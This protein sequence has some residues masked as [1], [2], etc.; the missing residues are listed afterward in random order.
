MRQNSPRATEVAG[1]WRKMHSQVAMFPCE[2]AAT[3]PGW[4]KFLVDWISAPV[5]TPAQAQWFTRELSF[6]VRKARVTV[7]NWTKRQVDDRK[8]TASRGKVNG[9][10]VKGMRVAVVLVTVVYRSLGGK[11]KFSSFHSFRNSTFKNTPK[12]RVITWTLQWKH[13]D[14]LVMA[15]TL[16]RRQKFIHHPNQKIKRRLGDCV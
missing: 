14:P 10:F 2:L 1:N 9:A 7:T 5:S 8:G 4:G 11:G 15:L 13:V 16:A 3:F 12:R 6:V